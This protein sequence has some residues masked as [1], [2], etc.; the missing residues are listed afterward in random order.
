[1]ARYNPYAANRNEV[2]RRA[3]EKKPRRN[4]AARERADMK[5]LAKET[6]DDIDLILLR[7]HLGEM[8]GPL[9]HTKGVQGIAWDQLDTLTTAHK[10]LHD[11]REWAHTHKWGPDA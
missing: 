3:A 1:M 5:Q 2:I 11:E 10:R 6:N 4:Q 8:H 7:N 9:G